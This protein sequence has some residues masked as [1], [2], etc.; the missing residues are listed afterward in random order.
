MDAEVQTAEPEQGAV[1][2]IVRPPGRRRWRLR[3]FVLSLLVAGAGTVGV[4]AVAIVSNNRGPAS[5]LR[6]EFG[7]LMPDATSYHAVV[8]KLLDAKRPQELSGLT[9]VG[10]QGEVTV[11]KSKKGNRSFP[12]S[13][14]NPNA[15]SVITRSI[16]VRS[17]TQITVEE[18]RLEVVRSTGRLRWRLRGVQGRRP[19]RAVVAPNGT[20]LRIIRTKTT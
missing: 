8:T 3:L 1:D 16:G 4:A 6:L 17:D 7:V 14:L 11:L 12:S 9:I 18:L 20:K 10:H 13:H 5:S 2:P 19:W 15:L